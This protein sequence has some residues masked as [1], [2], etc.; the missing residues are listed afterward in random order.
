MLPIGCAA[1]G[2]KARAGPGPHGPTLVC[3]RRART[4]S[5]ASGWGLRG[6]RTRRKRNKAEAPKREEKAA[7]FRHK[8]KK[9]KGSSRSARWSEAQGTRTSGKQVQLK[10]QRRAGSP[11]RTRTTGLGSQSS[12]GATRSREALEEGKQLLPK[13]QKEAQGG[14][15]LD[16]FVLFCRVTYKTLM[17]SFDSLTES[18]GMS[19]G[20]KSVRVSRWISA[21][22]RNNVGRKEPVDLWKSAVFGAG[23]ASRDVPGKSVGRCAV[24]LGDPP[25]ERAAPLGLATQRKFGVAWNVL[26]S[27]RSSIGLGHEHM[28]VNVSDFRFNRILERIC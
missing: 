10:R 28:S 20:R 25:V 2:S 1:W 12:Q 13:R 5:S 6:T 23:A 3:V 24:A 19:R 8:N 4:G 22:A 21:A 14:A 15:V 11:R 9:R 7:R 26:W 16:V 27:A 18:V 17:R